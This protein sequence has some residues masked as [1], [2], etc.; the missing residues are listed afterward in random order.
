M[1][2]PVN[3]ANSLHSAGLLPRRDAVPP[4]QARQA[5]AAGG[6]LLPVSA[7]A[8]DA[9]SPRAADQLGDAVATLESYL[10]NVSRSLRISVD[11]EAGTTVITVVDQATDEVVRQIPSEEV[12]ALA[13]FMAEQLQ[14]Q[15]GEAPLGMLFDGQG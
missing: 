15:E 11:E 5:E 9:L 14:S 8:A 13:R 6:K 2:S 12:L 7:T 1:A 4:A 10:Q 3:T